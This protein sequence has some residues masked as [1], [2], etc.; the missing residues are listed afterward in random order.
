MRFGKLLDLVLA[1]TLDLAILVFGETG[2]GDDGVFL[3]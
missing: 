3:L 1:E 2:M